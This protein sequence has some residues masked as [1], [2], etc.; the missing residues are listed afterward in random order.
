LS[1]NQLSKYIIYI[2]SIR[3]GNWVGWGWISLSHTHLY[4]YSEKITVWLIMNWKI[5]N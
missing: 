2:V 3:D 5:K 4:N 1:L